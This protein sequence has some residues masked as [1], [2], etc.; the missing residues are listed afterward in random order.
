MSI[1]PQ[2]LQPVNSV[3]E[4]PDDE[5]IESVVCNTPD[6]S[7]A[8]VIYDLT[9]DD[10]TFFNGQVIYELNNSQPDVEIYQIDDD[11]LEPEPEPNQHN[12]IQGSSRV[13][14]RRNPPVTYPLRVLRDVLHHDTTLSSGMTVEV[15]E[16]NMVVEDAYFLN[17][18]KI[19]SNEL[20]GEVILSGHRLQRTRDGNGIL[21][22]KLNEIYLCHEVDL[23]DPRDVDEQSVVEVPLADVVRTRSLRFTNRQFPRARHI[24][25]AFRNVDKPQLY[26]EGGLTLR[27]TYTCFYLTGTHRHNNKYGERVLDRVRSNESSTQYGV[28]DASLRERWRGDTITGGA[29]RPSASSGSS[30]RGNRKDLPFLRT[31]KRTHQE[32]EERVEITR[33]PINVIDLSNG[34]PS[35][36]KSSTLPRVLSLPLNLNAG[37]FMNSSMQRQRVRVPGQK[38][39]FGDA[40]CGAGGTTRGAEMA[41]LKVLWGFD[42]DETACT[43]WRQNFDADCYQMEAFRFADIFKNTDAAKVDIL[44]LSPP[45]QYFAPCH[46][47]AGPNDEANSA[48]LFAVQEIITIAKPRIVTLEQT[49]G[50]GRQRQHQGYLNSLIQMFTKAGFSVRWQIVF[51]APLVRIF[52]FNHFRIILI[53][54]R[55]CRLDVSD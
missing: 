16:A 7:S 4:I 2:I 43:T 49:L 14:P 51:L 41:G 35:H 55:G 29:F 20:T 12:K 42:F 18:V 38:Y 21:E 3:V 23:D 10:D 46:T 52:L 22:K 45:C 31:S 19:V 54:L 11:N 30:G 37:E 39:T 5:D 47:R 1:R 53:D 27:W 15:I 50:L 28:S 9:N 8:N 34:T 33:R 13:P 26:A 40:F 44:H 48:A 36:R 32:T 17:I 25:N 6:L 24:G